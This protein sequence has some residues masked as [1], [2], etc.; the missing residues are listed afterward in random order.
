MAQCEKTEKCQFFNDR[1]ENMPPTSAALKE[2]YCRTDKEGCARYRVSTAGHPVPADLFP[3]N[4]S[5]ARAILG[6]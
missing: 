2:L 3:H 6:R 1:M 5:R 4:D